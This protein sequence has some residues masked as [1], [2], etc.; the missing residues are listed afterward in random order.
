MILNATSLA[1]VPELQK[2]TRAPASA[3]SSP[4]SASA[5]AMPGS[6]AYRF[7]VWPS[8][9]SWR[10]DRLDD[11]GMAVAE[12]VDGDAAEQVD[13][14]LAVDVGDHGT[15]AAGQ[16]QRRGAVVVHHHAVPTL[17]E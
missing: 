14:G 5:S 1:S 12:N 3:P 9:F 10:G 2:N 15:V 17:L 6:V 13:V 7:D 8:V 11:G 4:T 16:R